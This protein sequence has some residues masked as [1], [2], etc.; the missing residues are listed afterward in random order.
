MTARISLRPWRSSRALSAAS[1][2]FG[3]RR[4]PRRHRSQASAAAARQGQDQG[5]RRATADPRRLQRPAEGHCHWTLQLLAD[6][7]VAL[8][9]LKEGSTE[10]VRQTLKKLGWQT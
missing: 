6:A 4:L 2:S 10:T 5:E 8:G 1:A 9:L 3:H 7:L